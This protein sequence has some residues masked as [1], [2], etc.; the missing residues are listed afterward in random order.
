MENSSNTCPFSCSSHSLSASKD[1]CPFFFSSSKKTT[2]P[3]KI[4]IP[5]DCC[6][7]CAPR[8]TPNQ[9][10]VWQSNSSVPFCLLYLN[11]KQRN[12]LKERKDNRQILPLNRIK[13]K[14]MFCTWRWCRLVKAVVHWCIRCW[15]NLS[16]SNYR[17]HCHDSNIKV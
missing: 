1:I 15:L 11:F 7:W 3:W 14:I 13:S 4:Q 10:K 9:T 2:K 17:P 8:L 6:D 12:A 5:L 16:S